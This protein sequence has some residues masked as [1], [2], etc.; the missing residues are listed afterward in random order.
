MEKTTMTYTWNGNSLELHVPVFAEEL[1]ASATVP[2]FEISETKQKYSRQFWV[3]AIVGFLI[4]IKLIA[5]ILGIMGFADPLSTLLHLALPDEM[6]LFKY[7]STK[8]AI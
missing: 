7:I 1:I 2:T 5:I 8:K 6:D 4:A 3:T